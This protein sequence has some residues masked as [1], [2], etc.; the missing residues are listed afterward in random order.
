MAGRDFG[1]PVWHQD[2]VPVDVLAVHAGRAVPQVVENVDVVED[3]V[4]PVRTGED[5][6]GIAGAHVGL[7]RRR[8]QVF[9]VQPPPLGPLPGEVHAGGQ[10]RE[11]VAGL[12]GPES[13]HGPEDEEREEEKSHQ[14]F[15][16][17]PRHGRCPWC[18][19]ATGSGGGWERASAPTETHRWSRWVPVN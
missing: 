8:C 5:H 18:C 10:V 17:E 16:A 19:N 3:A 12:E 7:S 2:V 4:V 11:A 13:H 1:V 15:P 6:L 14:R 9:H